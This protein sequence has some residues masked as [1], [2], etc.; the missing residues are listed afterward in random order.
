MIAVGRR[1]ATMEKL[2]AAVRDRWNGGDI[3][4]A[5]DSRTH[6][7]GAVLVTAPVTMIFLAELTR[8]R[9]Q[10]GR[11]NWSHGFFFTFFF[12]FSKKYIGP[13]FFQNYTSSVVGTA[14]ETY[15]RGGRRRRSVCFKKNN[16]F[17][18][19]SDEGKLYMKIVAFDEIF[20]F[21]FQSYLKLSSESNR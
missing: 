7:R 4:L 2:I 20:N 5:V 17:C 12:P 19:N 11:T 14:V 9:P 15:R 18:L 8:N 1:N 6:R 3:T 21:V 16:F 13:I 10:A